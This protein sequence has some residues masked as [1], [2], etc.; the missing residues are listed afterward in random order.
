MKL[1]KAIFVI[2]ICFLA[3]L[4][5]IS[6]ALRPAVVRAS[7][8]GKQVFTKTMLTTIALAVHT[9][10]RD[11]G[12]WPE[13]LDNLQENSKGIW[14]IDWGKYPPKQDGWHHPI[15]YKHFDSSL[16]FGSVSS[17]GSDGKPGGTGLDEDLEVRFGADFPTW[18]QIQTNKPNHPI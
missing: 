3:I 7:A 16:G 8:V 9:Y 12:Q 17:Y 18:E 14:Y 13:S 15:M 6:L 11:V 1:K 10:Y 4:F 5:S 2:V